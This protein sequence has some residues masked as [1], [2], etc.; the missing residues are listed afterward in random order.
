MSSPIGVPFDGS[1]PVEAL[2]AVLR[3]QLGDAPGKGWL[4]ITIDREPNGGPGT[5]LKRMLGRIGIVPRPGCK[6]LARAAQMDRA[7]PDWCEANVPRIVGWL[8]E[9]ATAR[10]LPFLDAAAAMLVKR[11]IAN[12]RRRHG[13][14]QG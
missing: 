9:E 12:A 5:D 2:A 3:E 11:A 10:G 13:E 4:R 7:G 6:C 1:V 14:A 8:R